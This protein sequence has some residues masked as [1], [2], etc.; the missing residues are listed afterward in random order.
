MR[1]LKNIA[2]AILHLSVLAS[3]GCSSTTESAAAPTN[4]AIDAGTAD[5][6]FDTPAQDMAS[7]VEQPPVTLTRTSSDELMECPPGNASARVEPFEVSRPFEMPE[8]QYEPLQ[9]SDYDFLLGDRPGS[10]NTLISSFNARPPAVSVKG[11][12]IFAEYGTEVHF[13][14]M[15]KSGDVRKDTIFITLMLDYEPLEVE[16]RLMAPDRSEIIERV[17][18]SEHRF[19]V[20]EEANGVL[21]DFVIPGSKFSGRRVHEL[22]LFAAA[23]LEMETYTYDHTNNRRVNIFYGGYDLPGHPCFDTGNF[24]QVESLDSREAEL[25]APST[26]AAIVLPEFN[27]W[28]D[29]RKGVDIAENQSHLDAELFI[30]DY[31][32]PI[33]SEVE[34]MSSVFLPYINDVPWLD[35]M[36]WISRL[37]TD[38]GKHVYKVPIELPIPMVPGIHRVV[39]F[40]WGHIYRPQASPEGEWIPI[41]GGRPD[42]SLPVQVR[43]P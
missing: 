22:S 1:T 8:P 35:G 33:D 24:V 6:A 2:I 37:G 38:L 41:P 31:S 9:G 32:V 16:F 28:E 26:S 17:V 30:Y 40:E 25:H 18:A 13:Q 3:M 43:R 15:M 4:A 21:V 42:E 20:D 14:F 10:R 36:L 7:D 29:S 11:D 12:A 34:N 27:S 19:P 23:T 5:G 39:Y